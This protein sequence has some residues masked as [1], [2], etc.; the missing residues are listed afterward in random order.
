MG[1]WGANRPCVRHQEHATTMTD[2]AHQRNGSRFHAGG[3]RS[4]RQEQ[5]LHVLTVCCHYAKVVLFLSDRTERRK[6]RRGNGQVVTQSL[7]AQ[8]SIRAS[9]T[10]S[11]S[12]TLRRDT[13]TLRLM[14][15]RSNFL[16][17][18]TPR[19]RVSSISSPRWL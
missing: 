14:L 15:R 10:V 12:E 18:Q 13:T 16:G 17:S 9:G 7:C 1:G 4:S 3:S 11:S 6:S 2:T 5:Q 8:G 19:Q